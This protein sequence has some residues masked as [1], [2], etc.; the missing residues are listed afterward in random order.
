MERKKN[1]MVK[2]GILLA[3][4]WIINKIKIPYFRPGSQGGDYAGFFAPDIKN[5]KEFEDL[6]KRLGIGFDGSSPIKKI[7]VPVP[8][9]TKGENL[10]FID[11]SCE[12][13]NGNTVPAGTVLGNLTGY[14]AMDN[15]DVK[16]LHYL[17]G[18][19]KAVF[20]ECVQHNL[21]PSDW[22]LLDVQNKQI[23]GAINGF[24]FADLLKSVGKG[25]LT[26][27]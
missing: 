7:W 9:L 4:L 25:M 13:D 2:G 11:D 16:T 23:L 18:D 20:P 3:I 22:V 14:A 12:D 15:G 26:A 1:L 10:V 17:V 24:N 27:I 21:K 6:L 5:E 8:I 19:D